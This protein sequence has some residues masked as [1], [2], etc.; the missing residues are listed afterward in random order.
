MDESTISKDEQRTSGEK[1][2]TTTSKEG[3]ADGQAELATAIDN[4]LET[5]GSKFKAMSKDI[6]GQCK[7]ICGSIME[8]H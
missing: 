6:M 5:V 2:D 7:Y 3:N 4:L 8:I 1:K